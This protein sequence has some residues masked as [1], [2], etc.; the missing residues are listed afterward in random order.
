M[1]R[2]AIPQTQKSVEEM[3]DQLNENRNN[4]RLLAELS[5]AYAQAENTRKTRISAKRSIRIRPKQPWANYVMVRLM[6]SVGEDATACQGIETVLNNET[7][8]ARLLAL[9]A[10]LKLESGKYED[11]AAYCRLGRRKFP[12]NFSSTKGHAHVLIRG[13]LDDDQLANVLAEIA[14]LETDQ[15]PIARRLIQSRRSQPELS[16]GRT[17]GEPNPSR[18]RN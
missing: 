11:A 8:D 12:Y 5:E 7:P 2:S 15:I 9:A 14:D 10:K 1:G 13:D 18:R 16:R 17:L 3:K 4:A 6:F